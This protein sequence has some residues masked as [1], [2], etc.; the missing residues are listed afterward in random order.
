MNNSKHRQFYE[1]NSLVVPHSFAHTAV[2][3]L[4][5]PLLSLQVSLNSY[6]QTCARILLGVIP[7]HRLNA[8]RKLLT[9]VKSKLAA[10]SSL[11]C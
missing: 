3:P 2:S 1:Y 9:S 6:Q 5:E 4:P 10:I 8:L 11:L 7:V